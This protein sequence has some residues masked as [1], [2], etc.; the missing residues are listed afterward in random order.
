[1]SNKMK[2]KSIHEQEILYR[3]SAGLSKKEIQRVLAGALN[4]LDQAGIDRLL[5]GLGSDTG[6]ALRRILADDNP[7]QPPVPGKAKVKED[8]NRHGRTGARV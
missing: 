4:S 5:Q 3:L 7:K 6:A 2:S 1:M 8:W